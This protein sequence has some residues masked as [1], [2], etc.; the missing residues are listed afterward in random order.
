MCLGYVVGLAAGSGPDAYLLRYFGRFQLMLC[1]TVCSVCRG[2]LVIC[3]LVCVL[4]C[5]K[6]KVMVATLRN[7]IA[8]LRL[9]LALCSSLKWIPEIDIA[10]LAYAVLP[11]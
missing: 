11:A 9:G 5:H 10:L 6:P 2:G 3:H 7:D 4:K 1:C 8:L